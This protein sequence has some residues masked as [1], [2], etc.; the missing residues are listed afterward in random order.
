[1]LLY[2]NIVMVSVLPTLIYAVHMS[3]RQISL[4]YNKVYNLYRFVPSRI[5]W[6][7]FTVFKIEG[8]AN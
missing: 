2:Y 7:E 6:L 5:K 3:P 1:M 4:R 8:S